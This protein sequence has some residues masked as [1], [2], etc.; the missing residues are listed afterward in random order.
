[1]T[2][3]L[4]IALVA[5]VLFVL[6]AVMP[7]S[8]A[9]NGT[10]INQGAT[11]FIGEQ[12]LNVTHVLNQA[13][14]VSDANLDS[15]TPTNTTI[16]WWASAAQIPSSAPTKTINLGVGTSPRYLSMTVA[17]SDFVGF[18]GNW[19]VLSGTKAINTDTAYIAVAD[20]S[21]VL[22]VWDFSQPTPTDVTGKSVPQGEKLG[23]QI[24]TNMYPAL[25]SSK[26]FNPIANGGTFPNSATDGYITIK[27]KD[28]NGATYSA[29]QINNAGTIVPSFSLLKQFVNDQPWYLGSSSVFWVTD[30]TDFNNQFLYP[31]GTYSAW[32]ESTLNL[33]KDNYKNAG[34]DYTGKTVSGVGTVTLVSDSVKI[35]ANKDSV[36]RSKSFSITV[37]GKPSTTY[38][39]WVKGTSTM[40]GGYDNQPPMIQVNQE[41]VYFDNAANAGSPSV[42]HPIGNYVFENSG[43]IWDDVAANT[44]STFNKTRYYALINTSTSGT[45]TVEWVTNNWTKAQKYTIRVEQTFMP[46]QLPTI[47]QT[48]F[49]YTPGASVKSDEVDVKVEKGAVTIVAAGDQSYYLGEEIKF[50]GTNTESYKTYLF[51]CGPN[52]PTQGGQIASPNPRAYP[53]VDQELGSFRIIDVNGDNT[54]SWK[55]GTS[56]VALDAG[57][58][59][60]YAVSQPRNAANQ[61]LANTAFGTVSIIIKKPFVSATASQSTV[62]QGDKIFITGTAEGNPVGVRIWILGKNYPTTVDQVKDESVNTDA[63]FKYE[64]TQSSTKTLYPGQYFVV[65]QHP[66]QN[67]VFDIYASTKDPATGNVLANLGA[68][69]YNRQLVATGTSAVGAKVFT[70][71]GQGS[72]QGSDAAEAL[73]QG[74][75]SPNVDDTYTKLQFLVEVPVIRI[76]AIG[77]KHVGDKFTITAATNLA[78]DDEILVQVYSSSFKPTQKSQSG[79][80]SGATGTVKVAKGDSGMNKISFDVDSS[81]FKPDEYIVTEEAILQVATGTA[82]FNVLDGTAPVVTTKSTVAV[83]TAPTAVPTTVVPTA[84]PTAIP[85]TKS[86]GYGALIALIG[87]GAVA[88]IVVRR[89]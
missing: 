44:S 13:G 18:T 6:M 34:A 85:T 74:I 53:V 28:A 39:V 65:V 42:I 3:R 80:F 29:L 60:I 59:T 70:L 8:A 10:V 72:L 78:V 22:A 75:N 24:N 7:V 83:T 38:Q 66:M 57:T 11:V 58:Y 67:N 48:A 36:V 21:L 45:R 63:S 79:E 26:R 33:M 56:A 4:T 81:T 88:F 71:L 43:S 77:D 86:P 89:H 82:L 62:A 37:T 40:S 17:P 76:D 47:P 25:D 12:G 20:P 50:S 84:I 31:V 68:N 19:Y 32:A 73:V 5:V 2:K 52:L 46:G 49:Y 54:W 9:A 16:G 87:L 51:I 1:M 30:A 41:K 61:N 14:G 23:F 64:V 35:E 69:V 15:T 27:V 55:W